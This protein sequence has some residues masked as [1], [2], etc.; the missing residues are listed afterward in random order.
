[1]IRDMSNSG[2]HFFDNLNVIG[3]CVDV[4]ATTAASELGVPHSNVANVSAAS[5]DLWGIAFRSGTLSFSNVVDLGGV[6]SV[7]RFADEA[8]LT[9]R[10]FRPHMIVESMSFVNLIGS[11]TI[12]DCHLEESSQ[13]GAIRVV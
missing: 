12:F 4:V 8:N 10:V 3:Y 5:L 6:S 11:Q 1:M 9:G 7:F 2:L 13:F